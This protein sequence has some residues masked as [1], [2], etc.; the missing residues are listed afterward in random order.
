ML[1][2]GAHQGDPISAYLFILA[3]EILFLFINKKPEITGLTIFD[4]CFFYSAYSDDTTFFLKDIIS[5]KNMVDTFHLF[6]DLPGLKPNLPK[7]E[8]TGIG[9]LKGVQEAVCGMRCA[10]LKNSTLKILGIQN[11]KEK[12]NYKTATNIQRVLKI[13]KMRNLILEGKIVFFKTLAISK[14]VFQSLITSVPRHIVNEL[15]KIQKS[16]LWKNSFPKIKHDTLCNDNKGGGLKHIDILSKI[17]SLQYLWIRRLYHNLFHEW[18]LIPSFLIKKS[19]GSSFKINSNLFFK[20]NKINFSYLSIRQT[21]YAG[22]NILPESLK[23]HLA[24]CLNI[25]GTMKIPR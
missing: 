17:I 9:V 19:C 3:I 2:R 18:K 12:K 14:T 5:I 1:G 6:S 7:C 21:F 20:R 24:L 4:H 13:W 22:K 16:F 10:G 8:I 11:L 23:Y 15:E 25:H